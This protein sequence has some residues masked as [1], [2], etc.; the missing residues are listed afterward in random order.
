MAEKKL[1]FRLTSKFVG[2]VTVRLLVR[3]VPV[4]VYTRLLPTAPSLAVRPVRLAVESE[5]AGVV[6]PPVTVNS[7]ELVSVPPVPVTV[8]LPVVAPAGTV[9]VR[10]SAFTTVTP[11]AVV[12]SNSTAGLEPKLNPEMVTVAPEGP[13]VGLK[14]VI[15]VG[16]FGPVPVSTTFFK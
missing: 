8:M 3:L 13:K 16:L 5:K 2:A 11:V 12:P 10:V 4:T 1:L 7:P 9:A 14:E 15:T 6:L